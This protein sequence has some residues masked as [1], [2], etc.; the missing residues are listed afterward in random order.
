MSYYDITH[1]GAHCRFEIGGDWN[2]KFRESSS[3]K[4][5]AQAVIPV[6]TACEEFMRH[7]MDIPGTR[8]VADRSLRVVVDKKT[9]TATFAGSPRI[10]GFWLSCDNERLVFTWADGQPAF[11]K[12]SGSRWVAWFMD[13]H[14]DL[15]D[16]LRDS[17]TE[18]DSLDRISDDPRYLIRVSR[19]E[20]EI[21]D[22]ELD[23]ITIKE[24]L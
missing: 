17:T 5:C 2:R 24:V 15:E 7:L 9:I 21:G 20:M 18:E 16:A 6:W 4:E 23:R 11:V 3:H 1:R 10:K 19:K 14:E 12:A 8:G 22:G 13:H